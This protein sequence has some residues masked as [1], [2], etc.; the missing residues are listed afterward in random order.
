MDTGTSGTGRTTFVNTLCESEV[1]Q[2][3]V[4]DSSE[5]AHQ[6]EGIKIKPANVGEWLTCLYKAGVSA[7]FQNSKRTVSVLH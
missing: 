4:C 6:E 5:T 1:L 2:H 3:K 7:L